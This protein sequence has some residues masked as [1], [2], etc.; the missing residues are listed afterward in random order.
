MF[1]ATRRRL[2][3]PEDLYFH[4]LRH[5]VASWLAGSGAT[6]DAIRAI[7]GHKPIAMASHYTPGAAQKLLARSAMAG[8]LFP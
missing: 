5:S 2:E 4:G 8:W 6:V 1:I 3:R 7:T